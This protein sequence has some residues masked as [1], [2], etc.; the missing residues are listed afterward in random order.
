MDNADQVRSDSAHQRGTEGA[1]Q[2]G[3][4]D[5]TAE[6]VPFNNQSFSA[7]CLLMPDR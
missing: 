3:G 4:W 1:V 6:A 5:G 7:A 2:V